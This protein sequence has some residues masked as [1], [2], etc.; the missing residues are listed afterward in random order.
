MHT[1][2]LMVLVSLWVQ[3]SHQQNR[4]FNYW[5]LKPYIYT[6]DGKLTGMLIEAMEQLKEENRET[7]DK[8]FNHSE[9]LFQHFQKWDQKTVESNDFM[10]QNWTQNL[11]PQELANAPELAA[12]KNVA[13]NHSYGPFLREPVAVLDELFYSEGIAMIGLKLYVELTIKFLVGLIL[14]SGIFIYVLL[15]TLF[16]SLILLV[17]VSA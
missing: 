17:I 7:C 6:D 8:K 9:T 13:L 15:L 4:T 5:E 10:R 2:F 14:F 12:S 3:H 11:S 1:H 16:V